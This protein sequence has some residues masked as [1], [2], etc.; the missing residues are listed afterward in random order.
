MKK[1]H[2]YVLAILIAVVGLS[3]I[4]YKWKVLNFPLQPATEAE[5]WTVQ[6]RIEYSPRRA[7][8]KVALVLPNAPPGFALL[9]ERFIA[10][11]YSLLQDTRAGNREAQWTIRSA[12]GK[13]V[14]Y[15]RAT[16]VRGPSDDEPFNDAPK[17]GEVPTLEEP[18]AA[19]AQN[20]LAE[21]R[22]GSADTITFAQD[23][24][25]RF[26][27]ENPTQDV[28]LLKQELLE[29]A[30]RARFIAQMLSLRH[31]PARVMYGFELGETHR[32]EKLLPWLQVHN[33]LRWATIDL[34]TASEGWPQDLFLWSR[35]DAEVLHVEETPLAHVNFTVT[36]NL[37]D[38]MAVA[39]Q[40]LEVQNADLVNYSL[41]SLPLQAQEV[42]RILLM[43]PIGAFIMLLLRNLVGVK[44]Y[45]TFMPILIALAFRETQLLAGIVLFGVVVSAGLL[46]RF[47]MERLR[48]LLV[49]RLTA[50]LI[51]VV[52]LMAAV[53]VISNRLGIEVGLSVALFP[54]VIMTMTI[55]RISVAWD[56]RG[57]GPALREAVGT[58]IVAAL[59]HLVMS[60]PPIEHFVFVF[61]EILLVL[62]AITL[63]LGRYSG[64]RL[65]E[66]FRFRNLARETELAAATK[67]SNETDVD[68][69][70]PPEKAP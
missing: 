14:L 1:S 54:M 10:R 7:A 30:E 61:P 26:T 15:Y 55:E 63:V 52:L 19:A 65:S 29:P 6:A 66:L 70:P 11:G 42:Y 32:D 44:T 21:V 12:R 27:M 57:G 67:V 17:V 48:L 18:F 25:R 51:V 13:Q 38:A 69:K 37:A 62:L 43:I 3:A 60:A 40:R 31:I 9:D 34:R 56:E 68:T 24:V 45:G 46:V 39:E 16:V 53:S 4:F 50:V 22:E 28:A 41:L 64:Y 5:V 2:L 49:P 36:R 35:A 58:L 59:A 33:G 20:V 23:L 8:N 47:Y